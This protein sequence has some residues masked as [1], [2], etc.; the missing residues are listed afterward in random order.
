MKLIT[1]LHRIHVQPLGAGR[2]VPTYCA[3]L[4]VEPPDPAFPKGASKARLRGFGADPR[5][6]VFEF[7]LDDESFSVH[8]YRTGKEVPEGSQQDPPVG[9][10]LQLVFGDGTELML[11]VEDSAKG[12]KVDECEDFS[13]VWPLMERRVA[14]FCRDCRDCPTLSP[15]DAAAL[16]IV[17]L[18]YA[19]DDPSSPER[20]SSFVATF[21]SYAGAAEALKAIGSRNEFD[22]EAIARIFD[23]LPVRFG[24]GELRVSVG[25]GDS[26]VLYVGEVLGSEAVSQTIRLLQSVGPYSVDEVHCDCPA[27]MYGRTIRACWA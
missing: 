1:N 26:P 22:G 24:G 4:V 12:V 10:S 19:V 7:Y 2:G 20:C 3:A 25:C 27:G 15:E 9:G 23:R 18:A 6:T 8:D 17:K 11:D 14:G 21:D 5:S 16:K 13:E